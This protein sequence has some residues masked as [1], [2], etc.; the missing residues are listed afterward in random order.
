MSLVW[1]LAQS[2]TL[3]YD[4][5]MTEHM[6]APGHILFNHMAYTPQGHILFNHMAPMAETPYTQNRKVQKSASRNVQND[7]Y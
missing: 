5:V 1:H 2:H 3:G 6:Y 4:F 7:Y